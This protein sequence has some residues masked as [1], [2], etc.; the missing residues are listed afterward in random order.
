MKKTGVASA[1]TIVALNGFKMEVL[2]SPSAVTAVTA[3]K[4]TIPP[5]TSGKTTKELWDKAT[6]E[7]SVLVTPP[8]LPAS[9]GDRWAEGEPMTYDY[10]TGTTSF[11]NGGTIYEVE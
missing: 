9:P 3:K 4:R 2:A 6:N 7:V 5:G 8:T 10:N 11:P 1:A